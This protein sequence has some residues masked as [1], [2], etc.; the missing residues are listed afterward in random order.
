[1]ELVRAGEA[2]DRRRARDTRSEPDLAMESEPIPKID[3]SLV[4]LVPL[5][6]LLPAFS[7]RIDGEDDEHIKM[8]ADVGNELPPILVHRPT[9]R[10]IDGMHRLGAATMRGD[11]M[12]RVQFFER[13]E[14]K[15][16]LGSPSVT[17][18]GRG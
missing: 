6:S 1:M 2:A 14:R 15:H 3:G 17:V 12:I 9:M 4:E 5:S 18:S 11:A 16:S 8:L 13:S 10:V 7:P